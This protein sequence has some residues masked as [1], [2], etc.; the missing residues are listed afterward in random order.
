MRLLV[1]EDQ[2]NI[3]TSL[4]TLLRQNNYEVDIASDGEEG[5]YMIESGIY[6]AI[7]LDI[8]MPKKNGI[9][10]LKSVRE[11]GIETPILLLTAK[12]QLEDKVLGLDSGADDYLTKPFAFEE[13][14]ARIKVMTRRKSDTIIKELKFSD[15]SLVQGSASLAGEKSK[16]E[17]SQKELQLI[18]MFLSNPNM[19]LKKE[20]ALEK[21]CGLEKDT[22]LNNVEVYIH[23]LRKKIAHISSRVQIRTVRRVGYILEEINDKE[24]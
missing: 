8:M 14:F 3:A 7:I 12:S 22:T 21:L 9:E 5:Q 15:V 23:F 17:L 10:V 18:E 1:C 11:S 24:I 20:V 4:A 19:I 16:V 6:D 2:K 13:L